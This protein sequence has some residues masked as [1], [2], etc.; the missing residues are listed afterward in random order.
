MGTYDA[1]ARLKKAYSE[2]VA[3]HVI[4]MKE[5]GYWNLKVFLSRVRMRRGRKRDGG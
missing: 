1:T 2:V 3:E 4:Q 5:G